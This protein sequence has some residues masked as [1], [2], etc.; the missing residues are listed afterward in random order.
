MVMAKIALSCALLATSNAEIHDRRDLVRARSKIP[1]GNWKGEGRG[2]VSDTLNG[3]LKKTFPHV[4]DCKDWTAEQLQE[5]QTELFR[6]RNTDFNDIYHDSSDNRKMHM[7]SLEDYQQHWA[8]MNGHAERNPHLKEMHRDAHCNEAVMWLVHHVNAPEQHTVFSRR[9]VPLLS[10]KAHQCG[11][12][13]SDSESALCA[14][15]SG[16]E[17][18]ME[19]HSNS[20]MVTQDWDLDGKIPEDPKFPGFARARRCDQNYDPPC[21]PCEGIGGP[22]WSDE[23]DGF[24]PTGCSLIA[25]ADEVP[26]DE[27]TTP[28]LG[29]QFIVHQLGSDR[30]SRVQNAGGGVLPPL[31]SQIRSTLWFDSPVDENGD[32]TAEDGMFKLRHDSFYDD[33]L[34]NKFDHG[35]VSEIHFQDKEMRENNV[36]GPM[37][38]L[39]HAT[40]GLGEYLGGC[41]CVGDPVGVPILGGM[42]NVGGQ[43]H[44]AFRNDATYMGRIQ[45]EI[46]YDGFQLGDKGHG[47]RTAKRNVTVDHF[48]KWFLHLFMDADPASPTYNQP[49]RFYG[50]YSGFAVYIKKEDVQPPSE[51]WD[52]A[53]V[54]NGWG[55]SDDELHGLIGNCHKPLSHYNCM[56][57]AHDE[58]EKICEAYGKSSKV[59]GSLM[60]GAFGSF[61]V[62]HEEQVLV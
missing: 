23:I 46:E 15:A 53:C 62:P 18:C 24:Q 20:G 21:G 60:K 30:L 51:V 38:S 31:Y 36:T 57:V 5:L 10:T 27:R 41:T 43:L 33:A 22:Y 13:L 56:N 16:K 8:E 35:L 50:P 26:E 14:T 59:E 1:R 9:P 55:T 52:T 17:T 2:G 28:E 19:C 49:L 42:L 54:D 4:K 47:D 44:S 40:L 58:D 34:Y 12:N 39:L 3:H 48:S 32:A 37:I 61:F 7:S 6:H 11:E 25:S 29:Q 45:M